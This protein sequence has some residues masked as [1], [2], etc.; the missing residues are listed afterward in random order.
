MVGNRH[1][2]PMP[3]EWGTSPHQRRPVPSNWSPWMWTLTLACRES[4]DAWHGPWIGEVY[5]GATFQIWI[6]LSLWVRLLILDTVYQNNDSL[7]YIRIIHHLSLQQLRKSS[8]A[9]SLTTVSTNGQESSTCQ[10]IIPQKN[11][12]KCSPTHY[13]KNRIEQSSGCPPQKDFVGW[14][15]GS[16]KLEFKSC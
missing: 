11:H 2:A 4:R 13:P 3:S 8:R 6:H 14:K 7:L 15:L 1:H 12:G 9:Q 10:K 16:K 5:Q